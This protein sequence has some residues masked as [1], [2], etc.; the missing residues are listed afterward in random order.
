VGDRTYGAFNVLPRNGF[1]RNRDAELRVSAG[2]FY[3]G[4]SG[5]FLRRS[6]RRNRLGMPVWTGAR[7]NYGLETRSPLST[8]MP[9]TQAAASYR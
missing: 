3:S 6:L 9:P 1:E 4:E 5:T 2:N 7:S 8:T